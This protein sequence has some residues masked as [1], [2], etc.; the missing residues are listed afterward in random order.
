MRSPRRKDTDYAA[1]LDR[2]RLRAR[3]YR[4]SVRR[5]QL[6]RSDAAIQ[7][8]GSF[9]AL[10]LSAFARHLLHLMDVLRIGRARVPNRLRLL[11]DLHRP[12]PG[13][14]ILLAVDHAHRAPSQDPEHHIDCRF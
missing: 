2:Y 5:R 6:W 8:R 7:P 3:L 4:S 11:D 13:D 10:H 12:D 14:W 9:A 1:R